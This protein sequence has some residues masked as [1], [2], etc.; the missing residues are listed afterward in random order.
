MNQGKPAPAR[1]LIAA[2]MALSIG[3]GIRGNYGHETGAMIPGALA[4]MA[5]V[6]LSGRQEWIS[7]IPYFAFF[8]AL[9]WS[10]GGSISY[11]Q[12]IGYTHS[13]HSLSV[14]YGF[15]CL[16]L[17]GF[18]WAALGGAGTV[19]PAC[20]SDWELKDFFPVTITVFAVWILQDLIVAFFIHTDPAFR[21]RDPLYWYDTDWLGVTAALVAVLLLALARRKYD[22]PTS[23]VVHMTVGW[24]IGF[25]V[26]VVLFGWR[27]TPP[28]GD[29]WAGC[30]GMVIATLIFFERKKWRLVTASSIIAGTIG[31]VGFALADL[32]K[33]LGIGTGWE[34]NWHSILEQSYGFMNGIGIGAV[35]LLLSKR[36]PV[37][38]PESEKGFWRYFAIG[39]VLIGI[40]YLNLRKNPGIWLNAKAVPPVLYGLSAEIWFNIGFALCSLM[41]VLL[42]WRH[43]YDPLPI[44]P[45]NPLGKAQ[46]FFAVF[47]WWI[48][49]G[50]FERALVSFA[51]QRLITE[52]V[53]LLNSVICSTL[54][55]LTTCSSGQSVVQTEPFHLKR[56][57]ALTFAVS[58]L[59][60]LFCWATIRT[61]Y[62]NAQ[63]GYASRHIR[64]GADATATKTKP[65]EDKPHP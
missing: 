60:P 55:L 15:A 9:G 1:L 47:L 52:G 20:L 27:M 59:T 49:I 16:Y 18:L 40:T 54:V 3:W 10:F 17:I 24:W 37:S 57:I 63:I 29:N 48:V 44:I 64:F 22:S 42:L 23:L 36:I 5:A 21:Q 12:V 8:G 53:I 34:T 28:R 62:G 61:I 56:T 25:L 45:Q 51:P 31:G 65:A 50:N 32:I 11:M 30:F 14:L 39:F 4:A 19:L 41:L 2:A 46:L 33:L 13:G 7:R 58:I 35:I 26:L 38:P 6:I 43:K